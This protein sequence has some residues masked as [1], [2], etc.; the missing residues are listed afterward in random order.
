MRLNM[1]L[2]VLHLAPFDSRKPSDALV[3]PSAR[4]KD[5]NLPQEVQG[6]R[7]RPALNFSAMWPVL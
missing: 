3:K 2:S 7:N 1:Q 4:G 6:N 5:P